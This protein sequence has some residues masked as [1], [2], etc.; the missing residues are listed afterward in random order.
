M[1]SPQDA[2]ACGSG[3]KQRFP[4]CCS[5]VGQC[6]LSVRFVSRVSVPLTEPGIRF[7]CFPVGGKCPEIVFVATWLFE[8]INT[9]AAAVPPIATNKAKV[10][11]DICVC[12]SLDQRPTEPLQSASNPL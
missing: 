5:P 6:S 3:S 1:A 4:P 11:N 7:E 8:E 12:K 10:A 9:V 2:A